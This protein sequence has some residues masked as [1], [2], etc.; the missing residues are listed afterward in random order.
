MDRIRIDVS[1]SLW[2]TDRK[3]EKLPGKKRPTVSAQAHCQHLC[4]VWQQERPALPPLHR[5]SLWHLRWTGGFLA[6]GCRAAC[7]RDRVRPGIRTPLGFLCP[8]H[9]WSNR[10][11]TT[12]R[13][14][15]Q[16][17]QSPAVSERHCC[18]WK[19][20]FGLNLKQSGYWHVIYSNC[21]ILSSQ[22]EVTQLATASSAI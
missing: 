11:K 18:W 8:P 21:G 16:W 22:H 5:W 12:L 4:C 3:R 20:T 15:A 19:H 17:G 7:H 6:E 14:S 2:C 10:A 13:T 9:H 1:S